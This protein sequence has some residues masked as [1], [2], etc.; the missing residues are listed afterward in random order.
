MFAALMLLVAACGGDD[1][2]DDSSDEE[3]TATESADND[4]EEDEE[5]TEDDEATP[6]NEEDEEDEEDSDDEEDGDDPFAELEEVT[7]EYEQVD[8]SVTYT[9]I[10]DGEEST[11]TV[12]TEGDNSRIDFGDDEGAFISI[13][14]PEASYTCTEGGGESSCFEGEGGIGANPFAGLFTSFASVEAIE[15]YAALFSDIDIDTSSE[16]VAGEDASCYSAS[17]D[18]EGDAGSVKWCFAGSGLLLLAIYDFESGSTELRAT[19][20]SDDVPGG[21]FDPPYEIVDLGDLGG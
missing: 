11:W 14:T 12:Y 7:D 18:F 21:I 4:D 2:D 3:T 16:E 19:E 20:F 8:G 1:D 17:G 10:T 15:A 5:E 13:T 6:E 9:V